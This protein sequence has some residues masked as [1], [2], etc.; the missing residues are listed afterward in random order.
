MFTVVVV[1][2]DSSNMFNANELKKCI[3]QLV[4]SSVGVWD[5]LAMM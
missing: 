5:V 4:D 2:T 1:A 3:G